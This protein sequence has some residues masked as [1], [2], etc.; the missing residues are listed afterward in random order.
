MAFKDINYMPRHTVANTQYVEITDD[1]LI[2]LKAE[3]MKW[4]ARINEADA[5]RSEE[6]K[7]VRDQYFHKRRKDLPKGQFG[8]NTPASY[9]G[10]LILNT[11]YGTQRDLSTKQ[12]Q[13]IETISAILAQIWDDVDPIRFKLGLL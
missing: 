6:W 7:T 13:A 12:I 2:W 10:G 1:D 9:I 3:L 11:V 8:E 5:Q 4:S